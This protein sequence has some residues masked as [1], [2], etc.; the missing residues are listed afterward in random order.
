MHSR[1]W[2]VTFIAS[3]YAIVCGGNLL[4]LCSHLPIVRPAPAFFFPTTALCAAVLYFIRPEFGRRALVGITLLA[5]IGSRTEA[6]VATLLHVVALIL[7]LLAG[8][9]TR[10]LV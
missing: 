7:F 10:A 3:F 5:I 2:Y 1:I 9:Q 8:K 6:P 4:F